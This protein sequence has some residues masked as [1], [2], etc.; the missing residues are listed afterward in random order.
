MNLIVVLFLFFAIIALLIFF[1]LIKFKLYGVINYVIGF[2]LIIIL[3]KIDLYGGFHSK[4]EAFIYFVELLCFNIIYFSSFLRFL[5]S[6][7]YERK[8]YYFVFPGI[9]YVIIIL[10]F[11]CIEGTSLFLLNLMKNLF[12]AYFPLYSLKYYRKYIR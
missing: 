8:R 11:I 9:F 1:I 7:E 6:E 3:C 5:F 10:F 4:E 2:V 12:L